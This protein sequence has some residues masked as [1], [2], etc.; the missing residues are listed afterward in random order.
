MHTDIYI[1]ELVNA[2]SGE[3]NPD[4]T[5]QTLPHSSSFE[6]VPSLAVGWA[7]YFTG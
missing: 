7:V 4:G 2:V 5:G 1:Q 6:K 3:R